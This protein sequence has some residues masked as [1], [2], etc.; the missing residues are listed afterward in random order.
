MHLKEIIKKLARESSVF[1]QALNENNVQK[2]WEEKMNT[3]MIRQ[4]WT[5][6][7]KEKTLL[8]ETSSSG[9]NQQ[10]VF[11]KKEI[12]EKMSQAGISVNA[13]SWKQVHSRSHDA[14]DEN[15]ENEKSTKSIVVRPWKVEAVNSFETRL[16]HMEYY[17]KEYAQE[18]QAQGLMQ[19]TSCG[20]HFNVRRQTGICI[21][22]TQKNNESKENKI[23]NLL[24]E[25]PWIKPSE[26]MSE[27]NISEQEFE[28]V[29]EKVM[30]QMRD[31][32]IQ[33]MYEYEKTREAVT[34]RSV[35]K[36]FIDYTLLKTSLTPDLI[37]DKII[38]QA[39]GPKVFKKIVK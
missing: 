1:R 8:L 30:A 15:E 5:V 16:M 19:C 12:I 32:F 23:K 38:E 4:V 34:K 33:G 6:G 39:V 35:E 9:W 22:C 11:M 26:A 18:W 17:A 27:M 24:K 36:L 3:E 20:R 25:V 7:L 28:Q 2:I 21:L 29:K 13:V 10:L 14:A 37:N 31:R